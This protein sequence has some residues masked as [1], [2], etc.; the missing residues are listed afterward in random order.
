MTC[1]HDLHRADLRSAQHTVSNGFLQAVVPGQLGLNGSFPLFLGSQPDVLFLGAS[2]AR[3]SSGMKTD[4]FW[5]QMMLLQSLHLTIATK[6]AISYPMFPTLNTTYILCW[7]EALCSSKE[8][9]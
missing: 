9:Q 7:K 2:T 8:C 6:T 1:K 3:V 4:P 5:C